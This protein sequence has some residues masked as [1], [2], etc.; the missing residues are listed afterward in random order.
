MS[1]LHKILHG[2]ETREYLAP[3]RPETWPL[4]ELQ[5]YRLHTLATLCCLELIIAS[6]LE[7]EEENP[8]WPL[9]YEH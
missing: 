1:K 8:T 3:G 5:V 2:V 4:Y 6:E 7:G 9:Y